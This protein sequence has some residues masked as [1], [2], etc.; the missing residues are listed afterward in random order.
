MKQLTFITLK[1]ARE[2]L[3]DMGIDINERQMKRAAEQNATGER[4]LPFIIDPITGTLR[5]EKGTLVRIYQE[6]QVNAENN[7]QVFNED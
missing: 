7:A 4:K 3:S 6:A 5:I 1:Q 2:T